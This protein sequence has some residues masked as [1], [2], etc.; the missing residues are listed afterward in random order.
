VAEVLPFER[1]SPNR[2]ESA[3]WGQICI[4]R[5]RDILDVQ[6]HTLRASVEVLARSLFPCVTSPVGMWLL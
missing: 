5:A 6:V 4:S 1:G 2:Q 3:A